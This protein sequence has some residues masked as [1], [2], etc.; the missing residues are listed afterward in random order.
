MND[1]TG[2]ANVV[3]PV[4]FSSQ[5]QMYDIPLSLVARSLLYG[6]L[7]IIVVLVIITTGPEVHDFLSNSVL[8]G[9]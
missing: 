1:K 4:L 2:E 8:T 7:G 5:V 6:K 3:S 9:R